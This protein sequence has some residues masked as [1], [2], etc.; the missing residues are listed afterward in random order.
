MGTVHGSSGHP[1]VKPE[2]E[3][4]GREGGAKV[5]KASGVGDAIA[6][7]RMREIIHFEPRPISPISKTRRN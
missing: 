5:P 2:D 7:N 1:R 6:Q 4:D 3:D